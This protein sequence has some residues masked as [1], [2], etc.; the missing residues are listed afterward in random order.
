VRHIGEF[1]RQLQDA[2]AKSVERQR[3]DQ[4][5]L[6]EFNRLHPL[7]SVAIVARLERD[8]LMPASSKSSGMTVKGNRLIA[9]DQLDLQP[10]SISLARLHLLCALAEHGHRAILVLQNPSRELYDSV[11]KMATFAFKDTTEDRLP[12]LDLGGYEALNY[13]RI[14][15]AG[16]KFLLLEDIFNQYISGT[17]YREKEPSSPHWWRH[18]DKREWNRIQTLA[19]KYMFKLDQPVEL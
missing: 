16:M 3:M 11:A 8:I 10:L 9:L 2:L 13:A 18:P 4:A 19:K 17:Q 7:E 15:F 12:Q 5:F 6:E 14:E 1:V